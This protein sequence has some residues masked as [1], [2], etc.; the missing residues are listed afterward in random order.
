ME[1]HFEF[2]HYSNAVQFL[3]EIGPYLH[4]QEIFNSIFINQ[5]EFE[6]ENNNQCYFSALMDP[7]TDTLIFALMALKNSFL[8]AS[9]VAPQYS[10]KAIVEH[11]VKDFLARSFPF[12]SIHSYEPVLDVV[13]STILESYPDKEL[14]FIDDCWGV[15]TDKI[16]WSEC[17]LA[18]KE[19][20]CLK[21]AT[22]DELPLIMTWFENYLRDIAEDETYAMHAK[23]EPLCREKIEQ[24]WVYILYNKD[25]PLSMA[26]KTRPLLH[27]CS[28]A[29]VYTP[30]EHRHTGNA[31]ACISMLTERFLEKY[32][33][34]SLFVAGERD[35]ENNMY[36]RI[37]YQ[38][39]GRAAR[40]TLKPQKE[41][42]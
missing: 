2:K 23:V 25:T 21:L 3:A 35:P 8:Y 30:E 40:Y 12:S 17:T 6:A 41:H 1:A 13:K 33:Y 15:H 5:L 24:Q 14:E 31:A 37:G 16:Q 9:G 42:F 20:T 10:Y 32:K 19:K 34:V 22:M 26:W 38:L 27:G 7:T 4:V 36:S 18:I 29:H 11:C 28:I 39:F